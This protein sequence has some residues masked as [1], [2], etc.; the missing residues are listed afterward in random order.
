MTRKTVTQTPE[1]RFV[2]AGRAR[3]EIEVGNSRFIASLAPTNT[4]EEARNFIKETSLTF[5]D[6]SHHV[7]AFIIGHGHSVTTHASDAGEPAGTAGQ[8]AL[9]VL[10]GSGLGNVTVVVTRYF[11][12]TKL[13]TGGLARA[14]AEAVKSVLQETKRA[15]LVHT[16]DLCLRLPYSY[17]DQTLKLAGNYEGFELEKSFA[18]EVTLSIRLQKA[19]LDAF[20]HDLQELTRGQVTLEILSENPETTFPIL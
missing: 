1:Q 6:A 7:P 20:D 15:R 5:S 16:V 17:F 13:G 10:Q 11:G 9:R 3:A 14:Y 4:V 8:P 2:P 19:Y 18:E 12:G